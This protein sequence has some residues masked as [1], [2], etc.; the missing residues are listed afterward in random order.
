MVTGFQL[1]HPAHQPARNAFVEQT[2]S[3][4]LG[5]DVQQVVEIAITGFKDIFESHHCA[6][7]NGAKRTRDRDGLR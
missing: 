3:G 1:H 5:C 2:G 6:T 4:L 7:G